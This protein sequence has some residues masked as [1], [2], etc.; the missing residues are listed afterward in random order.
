MATQNSAGNG[1]IMLSVVGAAAWLVPGGGYFVL[2]E[3][4]RAWVVLVTVGLTFLTGL[5]VG[6]MGVIDPISSRPWYVAQVMNSPAVVLIGRHVA[7]RKMDADRAIDATRN[8]DLA[9]RQQALE[10]AKATVYRVYGRPGEVGQIYTSISGLLNLLCIV[11]AMYL[12]HTRHN[13]PPG[14][15]ST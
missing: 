4:R 3:H 10:Q 8:Q 2:G 15:L 5:Y 1:L 11:N 9:A 14:G 6:S 7:R 12:V 13:H